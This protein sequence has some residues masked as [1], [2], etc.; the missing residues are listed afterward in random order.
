[1]T[2]KS[3]VRRN[4]RS[5]RVQR[6]RNR[7][8]RRNTKRFTKRGR[9]TNVRKNSKKVNSKRTNKKIKS[10]RSYN[11]RKLQ[12]GGGD[13]SIPTLLS[14]LGLDAKYYGKIVHV[15]GRGRETPILG[16][17]DLQKLDGEGVHSPSGSPTG[18]FFEDLGMDRQESNRMIMALR[19]GIHNLLE[20]V[21]PQTDPE[22]IEARILE[23]ENALADPE[24]PHRPIV[25]IKGLYEFKARGGN[26][27]SFGMTT[28]ESGRLMEELACPLLHEHLLYTSPLRENL[29]A[30][31]RDEGDVLLRK[32]DVYEGITVVKDSTLGRVDDRA[33]HHSGNKPPEHHLKCDFCDKSYRIKQKQ[34]NPDVIRLREQPPVP[35][36]KDHFFV[37]N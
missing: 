34:V 25:N 24:P 17:E 20:V 21:V 14:Q 16:I 31:S 29:A 28:E 36:Q 33:E 8:N 11:K 37:R 9:R 18:D 27:E 15:G 22:D 10:R 2:R 4:Q 19:S 13:T 7:S 1:M 23:V 12:R 32:E 26:F 3:K 6:N 35:N 30:Y 5:K